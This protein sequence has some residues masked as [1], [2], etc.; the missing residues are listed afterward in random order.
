MELHFT[1]DF[2]DHK[3]HREDQAATLEDTDVI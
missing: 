1:L 2:R 3:I